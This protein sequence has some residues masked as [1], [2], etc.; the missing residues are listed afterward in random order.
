M[1]EVPLALLQ[2]HRLWAGP[3]GVG[4]PLS[5][6]PLCREALVNHRLICQKFTRSVPRADRHSET[7]KKERK[8]ARHCGV[9]KPH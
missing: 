1:A 4:K 7:Q 8:C 3:R 2:H 5:G 6:R 9:A